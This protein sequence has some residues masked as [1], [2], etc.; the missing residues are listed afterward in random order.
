MRVGVCM[1]GGGGSFKP[2]LDF[3]VG[4]VMLFF[5]GFFFFLPVY[6]LRAY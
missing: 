4:L 1:W 5:A 6:T 2:L 3:D